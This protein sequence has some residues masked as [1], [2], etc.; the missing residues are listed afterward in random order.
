MDQ[1]LEGLP[2]PLHTGLHARQREPRTERC[3]FLR[4]PFQIDQRHRPSEMLVDAQMRKRT[5]PETLRGLT[6]MTI[7]LGPNF[8]A[9]ET[10]DVAIETEWGD[11]LGKVI[12]AGATQPLRGEPRAIAGYARDRYVYAPVAGVFRTKATIGDRVTTCQPVARIGDPVLRAPLAGTLRGLTHDGV[13]VKEK[14]K[15]IE[16]DPR[17][18][19]ASVIGIGERPARIADGVLEAIRQAAP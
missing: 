5:Q 13:P 1:L 6:P 15:V 16:V 18:E 14:T 8:V 7:G 17:L 11:A 12:T 9:S 3:L 19:G 4:D 2:A 10:V